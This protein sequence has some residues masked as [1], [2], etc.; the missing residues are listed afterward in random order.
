MKPKQLFEEISAWIAAA[1]PCKDPEFLAR[2]LGSPRP[3]HV[4]NNALLRQK[5]RS[6]T[7][8]NSLTVN[9][10]QQLLNLLYSGP[11]FEHRT[12][13]GVLLSQLPELRAQLDLK[14]FEQWLA[15]LIGWCEIDMNCQSGWTAQELLDRWPEWQSFLTECAHSENIS[16]RRAS[17]VLLVSPLRESSDDQLTDQA[18][19]T[20]QLLK[21]E[22]AILITKAIS[23]VLRS[24]TRHQP[25][26]VQNFLDEHEKSLPAIAMRE[27]KRKLATGKK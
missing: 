8:E 19:N 12:L 16:L 15:G 10:Y 18:L 13:A 26:T 1:G 25:D 6:I 24:M 17:L 9:E 21:S 7:R 5:A 23:W 22:K 27:T 20:V 14:Q 2:Y 4:I 3:I 11:Y